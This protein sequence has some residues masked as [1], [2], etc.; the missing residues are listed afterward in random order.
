M[1]KQNLFF[2]ILIFFVV[3]TV[4]ANIF[5][6]NLPAWYQEFQ[7]PYGLHNLKYLL[8]GLIFVP[9]YL[10]YRKLNEGGYSITLLG[11]APVNG[12]IVVLSSLVLFAG[13]GVSNEHGLNEHYYGLLIGIVVTSYVIFEE[14]GW[15][16][17][18]QQE[19]RAVSPAIR[20]LVIGSIWYLWHLFFLSGD[21]DPVREVTVLAILIAG[22]WG[23]GEI[24]IKTQ[25]ILLCS[26]FHLAANIVMFSPL[27]AGGMAGSERY[28]IASILLALGIVLANWKWSAG[29]IRR[30]EA[31]ALKAED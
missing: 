5:R 22:S 30:I 17:V 14:M 7:L 24:A 2:R 1:S 18:L 9:I 31:E 12:V 15:R 6:F 25:S 4:V 8:E 29:A 3:A 26:V 28:I 21:I 16:G 11:R 27:I 23:L 19:L 10:A 20:Y 13:F